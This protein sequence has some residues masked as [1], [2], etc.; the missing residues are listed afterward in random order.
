[1]A[2]H[3]DGVDGGIQQFCAGSGLAKPAPGLLDLL[4]RSQS[5]DVSTGLLSRVPTIYSNNIR[6]RTRHSSLSTPETTGDLVGDLLESG[7]EGS[8]LKEE[9]KPSILI[10]DHY[11]QLVSHASYHRGMDIFNEADAGGR[12]PG[13][14]EFW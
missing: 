3:R 12:R 7:V 1:M 2:G 8:T 10:P 14:V 9:E 5:R 6:L 11:R 4:E 13:G